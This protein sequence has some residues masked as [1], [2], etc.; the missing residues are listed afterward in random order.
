[1]TLALNLLGKFG[2]LTDIL[3]AMDLT[4]QCLSGKSKSPTLAKSYNEN[5]QAQYAKL[6]E[7]I[8]QS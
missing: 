7:V 8:Q 3:I 6:M 2:G 4:I 1:M 5:L